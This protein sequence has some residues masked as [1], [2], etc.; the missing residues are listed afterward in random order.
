MVNLRKPASRALYRNI[1][2]PPSRVES[3]LAESERSFPNIVVDR[4]DARFRGSIQSRNVAGHPIARLTTS[5]LTANA[6]RRKGVAAGFHGWAKLVWQVSGSSTFEGDDAAFELTQGDAV[7][8]PMCEPYQLHMKKD[9]DGIM[10]IFDPSQKAGWPNLKQGFVKPI[11]GNAAVAA[12]GAAMASMLSNA[13][14]DATDRLAVDFALDMILRC[15]VTL[16][17]DSAEVLNTTRLRRAASLIEQNLA[18]PEYTPSEIAKD[19]GVSRRTLYQEF[20][21]AGI[22][23]AKLA[24]RMRLDQARRDILDVNQRLTLMEIALKNGF[25]DS[26]SFS[27]AFRRA[28]G[29]APSMLKASQRNVPGS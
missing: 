22:S 25:A 10:M 17:T 20:A 26:S 23:P 18:N 27:H 14:G 13:V 6:S 24:K 5:G 16:D 7:V 9:Y 11:S 3:F 2:S 28:F 19:L 1:E 12:A 21:A 4:L 15:M 8:L 29:T